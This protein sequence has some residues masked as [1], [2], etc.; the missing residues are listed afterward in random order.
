MRFMTD[1]SDFLK[2]NFLFEAVNIHTKNIIQIYNL[3]TMKQ[4]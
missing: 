3:P 2:N 4:L 1:S